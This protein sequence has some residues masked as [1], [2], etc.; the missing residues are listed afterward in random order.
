MGIITCPEC[1]GTGKMP[2]ICKDIPCVKCKG[3]GEVVEF[4]HFDPDKDDS[5]P[6]EGTFSQAVKKIIKDIFI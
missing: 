5:G 2:G 4:P 1:K 6:I 3:K